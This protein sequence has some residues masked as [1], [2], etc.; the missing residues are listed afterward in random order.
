[1][2]TDGS[3]VRLRLD[4]ALLIPECKHNLVSLALL[5]K[6]QNV[7]AQLGAGANSCLKLPD[8]REVRL[9]EEGTYV[10]PDAAS[11][12]I[13]AAIAEDDGS[14]PEHASG[15]AVTWELLHNRFNGRS[16]ATL[17]NLVSSGQTVNRDWHRALR[18]A[19]ATQCHAC[20][21]ARLDR[22]PSRSHVPP[23]SEPGH[24]SYD[25]FEMGVPHMH[26]GQ[27]YVIGYDR[28]S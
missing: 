17:R 13:G 7:T 25:I 15:T 23:V 4:D 20:H 9:L 26:G 8:G 6:N 27:R 21:H 14:R 22:Q 18:H 16:H 28:F 12:M 2:A 11:A 3:L 24:I 19:P 5:A 10:I 1:M